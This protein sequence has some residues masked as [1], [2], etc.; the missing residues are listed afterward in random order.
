[1][2]TPKQ[3]LR[4]VL[5]TSTVGMAILGIAAFLAFA[6]RDRLFSIIFR[7]PQDSAV[8]QVQGTAVMIVCLGSIGAGFVAGLIGWFLSPLLAWLL[9]G[10]NRARALVAIYAM[11]LLPTVLWAYF[12]P[13]M[14]FGASAAVPATISVMALCMVIG[15]RSRRTNAPNACSHCG[16]DLAGCTDPGCPECGQGRSGSI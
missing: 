2:P 6:L 7:E 1:M 3:P 11:C 15:A 8:E 16:Y 9:R 10:T 13:W 14:T 4:A 12:D 5:I